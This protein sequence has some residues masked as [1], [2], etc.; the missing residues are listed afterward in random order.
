M[1]DEINQ[2]LTYFW[3]KQTKIYDFGQFWISAQR[4]QA[5]YI[6]AHHPRPL[7]LV[8]AMTILVRIQMFLSLV[9]ERTFTALCQ[10]DPVGP[11]VNPVSSLAALVYVYQ[12]VVSRRP[13][14]PM[15]YVH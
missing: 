8:H 12:H 9:F 1:L 2:N 7:S 10:E 4:P 15:Q 3:N 14:V 11:L 6:L 13:N 5:N